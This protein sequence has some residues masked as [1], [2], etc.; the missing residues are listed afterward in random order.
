MF[1]LGEQN[2]V[3]SW[4]GLGSVRTPGRSAVDRLIQDT[5]SK[6]SNIQTSI[7]YRLSKGGPKHF[8]SSIFV[9][10]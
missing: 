5:E 3:M 2:N 6:H 1:F 4:E 7:F 9:V 8:V 10:L